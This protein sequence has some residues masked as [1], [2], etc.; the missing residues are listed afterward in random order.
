ME[1]VHLACELDGRVTIV[2]DVAAFDNTQSDAYDDVVKVMKAHHNNVEVLKFD[3]KIAMVASTPWVVLGQRHVPSSQLL[4]PATS[5]PESLTLF[6]T[7]ST[8]TACQAYVYV[9]RVRS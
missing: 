5:G 8:R 6:P 3:A 9:K 4:K 2:E 7:T 1:A